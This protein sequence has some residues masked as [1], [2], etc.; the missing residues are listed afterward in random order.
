MRTRRLTF[1][2]PGAIHTPVP[3]LLTVALKREHAADAGFPFTVP[4]IRSLAPLDLAAPVTLFVGANGS[5]KSTLLEGIAAAARLPSVGAD[6]AAT[7]QT[8]AA[9]RRPG[10]VLRPTWAK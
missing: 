10:A 4:A 3:H 7:D 6:E 5:G 8:L 2:P 1:V 9:Q